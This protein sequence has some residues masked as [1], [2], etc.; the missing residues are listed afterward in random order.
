LNHLSA[1]SF[2]DASAASVPPC[3]STSFELTMPITV[4]IDGSSGAG[5]FDAITTVYLSLAVTVKP[6]R[7]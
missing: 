3:S 7:R 5:V 4:R 1:V 6:A 2:V